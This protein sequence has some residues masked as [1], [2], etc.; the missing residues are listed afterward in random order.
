MAVEQINPPELATPESY[1]HVVVASGSKL[2]F[3][4]GQ[5]SEDGRGNPVAR[6]NFA[7]QA[8]R[9]FANVGI[10]LGA[11]GAEPREVT[12]LTIF[13]VGFHAGLLPAIEAARVA[14]FGAHR[15][16]DTLVGVETLAHPG[17]LIEVEA[18]AVTDG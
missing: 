12:K 4:S 8:H 2:V 14:L 3:V 15:P 13:V 17:C 11:A 18:I 1:T 7:A 5:V 6:D 9:A 16:A 10:A